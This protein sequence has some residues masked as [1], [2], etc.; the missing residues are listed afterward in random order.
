VA[1][2]TKF[3]LE[4]REEFLRLLVDNAGNVSEACAAIGISRRAA[5]DYRESDSKF[6]AAWDDAI[7]VTTEALEKEI[8]RRAHEGT[9]EPVFY[10][11]KMCGEIRKYSDTLA[12]FILK[13][14]KP[15]KYR[16][17]LKAEIG[18]PGG[19]PFTIRIVYDSPK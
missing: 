19:T 7:Q 6:R 3:T 10:Q 13:G 2:R 18:G 1:N 5:Y 11:G 12:M 16:E 8:Y 4:K 9:D 17:N 15:E 14:R